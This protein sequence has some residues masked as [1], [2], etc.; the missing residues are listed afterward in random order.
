[1]RYPGNIV[2]L[3]DTRSQNGGRGT[4]DKCFYCTGLIDQ[5]H[6]EDCVVLARPIRITLSIDL[7]V[8]VPR[9]LP[10]EDV[11]GFFNDTGSCTN[12]LLFDIERQMDS[13][14]CLCH[15]AEIH[16]AGE[17]DIDEALEAG[18]V[19]DSEED[20]PEAKQK[21]LEERDGVDFKATGPVN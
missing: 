13:G 14:Y 3:H 8:S 20:G 16:Y 11:D 15:N 4:P 1:M 17:A 2:T 6:E 12:N 18:L 21:F 19:P 5:Q 10:P 7:V 9:D